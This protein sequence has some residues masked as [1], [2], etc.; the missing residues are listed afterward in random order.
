MFPAAAVPSARTLTR[1]ALL[2]T[3]FAPVGSET[4]RPAPFESFQEFTPR[5]PPSGSAD[6]DPGSVQLGPGS[7]AT[8]NQNSAM[9]R[10]DSKNSSICTGFVT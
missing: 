2:G 8:R 5:T 1:R 6:G 4:P 10:I 9:A 3:R 7:V